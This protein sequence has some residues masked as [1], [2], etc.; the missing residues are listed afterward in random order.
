[1]DFKDYVLVALII[2]LWTH[3]PLLTSY[4]SNRTYEQSCKT[5]ENQ[6]PQ[7]PYTSNSLQHT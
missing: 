5:R 1:M 4:V 6:S 3:K 7:R 2:R